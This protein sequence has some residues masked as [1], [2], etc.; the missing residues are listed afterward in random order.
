MH[1][2][3]ANN[4]FDSA[5]FFAQQTIEMLFKGLLIKLTG[6][7]PIIHSTAEL[8]QYLAKTLNVQPLNDVMRCAEALEMHY[9]QARYPDARI[10]DYRRWEAEEAIRCMEVVWSYVREV[11]GSVA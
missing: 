4:R 10:N 1:E 5:S 2:D 11:V 8:L 9:I 6:T 7:R 3:L